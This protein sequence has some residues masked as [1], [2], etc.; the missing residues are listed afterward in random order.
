M[1]KISHEVPACL[2]EESLNFND[3]D[4][5][6]PHLL[7]SNEKYR[8]FF[9]KSKE[10]GREIYLDNSLHELGYAMDN[11][12]LLKWIEILEPSNF[13]VPDVWENKTQSTI[14]A[15]EWS[16]INTPENTTKIAVVQA[17]SLNDAI[18]CV[19]TYVDLGYKKIAFSYGANYYSDISSHPNK[20][21]SKA[22]GRV[23]VLSE[24]QNCN[25]L[26][27]SHKI[28]LLGTAC[29]VEFTLYK[30]IKGIESI[31]TSNP[32]MAAIEN[33][34]YSNV[35]IYDKPKANLNNFFDIPKEKIDMDLVTHNVNIFKSLIKY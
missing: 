25:I 2:L 34:K 33:I 35:G 6:L 24:I 18:L 8:N 4:Y 32:I 27:P 11:K 3:Y 30:D 16:K 12:T 21:I 20:S 10:S 13:F 23:Q 1:I 29:P 15:R 22:L 7:E 28:H 26:T 19:R 17:Q 31:D 5:A 9:L 14:K